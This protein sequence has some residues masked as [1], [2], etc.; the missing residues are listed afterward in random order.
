MRLQHFWAHQFCF[1]QKL[2]SSAINGIQ[3]DNKSR[4]PSKKTSDMD[5]RAHRTDLPLPLRPNH[6]LHIEQ[7]VDRCWEDKWVMNANGVYLLRGIFGVVKVKKSKYMCTHHSIFH[8]TPN[9][10]SCKRTLGAHEPPGILRITTMGPELQEIMGIDQ[11]H[12]GG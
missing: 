10:P 11:H 12:H 4:K 8:F 2:S 5:D 6:A 1:W 9:R 7:F 3:C